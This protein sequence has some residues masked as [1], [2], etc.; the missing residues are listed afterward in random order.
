[1]FCHSE[2]LQQSVSWSFVVPGSSSHPLPP[3]G[4]LRLERLEMTLRHA[5]I[6]GSITY[7]DKPLHVRISGLPSVWPLLG[8]GRTRC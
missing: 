6:Y 1:M 4:V 8:E 2:Y 5:G 7:L 3:P